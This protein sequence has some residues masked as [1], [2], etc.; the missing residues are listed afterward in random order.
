MTDIDRLPYRHGVGLVLFNPAGLV[1]VGRRVDA[2]DDAW[3]FPQGGIDDGEEPRAA[4]LREL[5]EEIGSDRAQIIAETPDW[6]TYDLPAAIVPKVWKGRYR[7][8]RQKWFALRFL[9]SDEDIELDGEHPEF[10]AWRW[11]RLADTPGLIVPFKRAIYLQVV[12]AF[13][14]LAPA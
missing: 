7:G 14:H 3:Q 6:L 9:G 11:V 2:G 1:F 10:D 4:A 5:R 13:R 8:Q 12:D